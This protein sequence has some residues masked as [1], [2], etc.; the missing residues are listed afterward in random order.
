MVNVGLSLH[1][2]GEHTKVVYITYT[3]TTWDLPDIYIFLCPRPQKYLDIDCGFKFW[4]EVL[5]VLLVLV[6]PFPVA[7]LEGFLGFQ[8]KPSFK[9]SSVAHKHCCTDN[10]S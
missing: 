9:F 4:A 1:L 3:M 6:A 2:V 8:Q 5:W 7:D 10:L